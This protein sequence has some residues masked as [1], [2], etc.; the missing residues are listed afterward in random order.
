MVATSSQVNAAHHFGP[1]Y[2]CK[3]ADDV[4]KRECVGKGV[5]VQA[6]VVDAKARCFCAPSQSM[7]NMVGVTAIRGRQL[8]QHCVT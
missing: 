2:A 6:P 5:L 4:W 7:R 8:Q 3:D 1:S